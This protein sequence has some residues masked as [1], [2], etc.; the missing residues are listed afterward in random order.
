[1]ERKANSVFVLGGGR[2][3]LAAVR[4]LLTSPAVEHIEIGDIDTA[5]AEAFA[6]GVGSRVG[7]RKVD[8]IDHHELVAAIATSQVVINA[9]W[10]EFNVPVM[11]AAIDAKVHY[12]DM[13]G[14]FHVTKKQLA[15]NDSAKAAGVIAVLGAGESPGMT[16]IMVAASSKE[17]DS[18]DEVRIRVGGREASGS[19]SG[20]LMFPFAVSTVFDEYSKTPVMFLE[21]QFQ[22]VEPL[23][24][25][26]DVEFPEPVGRQT[27]HYSIHSEIATLPSNMRVARKVDFKLGIADQIYTAIKPFLDAG[28]GTTEPLSVNRQLVSPR[29]VAI[30]LLTRRASDVEPSRYVAVRTE[31]AGLRQGKSICQIR[32]LVGR[33]SD[34]T[35]IKNATAL[36]TGI[37]ASVTAQLLL[38]GEVR[39]TGAMAPESCVPTERFMNEL[40]HRGIKVSKEEVEA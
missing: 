25:A 19:D 18:I 6:R 40:A 10:Y 1:L 8:L 5:K 32:Q 17:M 13:G 15:L 30:A 24:G 36:L 23:S 26:E 14:L 7:V 28:M 16:N 39:E 12:V 2:V 21:G 22:E 29:D 20:K 9:S 4:D 27:C 34:S 37:G 33:P 11:E 3:G 31:V 35:G 38:A